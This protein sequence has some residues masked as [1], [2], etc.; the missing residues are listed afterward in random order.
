MLT[1][2][3]LHLSSQ[4]S[5]R[6]LTLATLSSLVTSLMI[7]LSGCDTEVITREVYV[8]H[9]LDELPVGCEATRLSDVSEQRGSAPEPGRR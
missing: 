5:L 9:P 3:H 4:L 2:D 1:L 7:L 6:A 8:S